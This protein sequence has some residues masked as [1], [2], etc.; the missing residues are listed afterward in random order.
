MSD[1]IL[2]PDPIKINFLTE[3]MKSK[4]TLSAVKGLG[5]SHYL[6]VNEKTPEKSIIQYYEISL[7]VKVDAEFYNNLRGPMYDL[8]F[9][10]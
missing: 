6:L 10:E 7:P 2:V 4:I 3:N 1:D 9:N 5:S 8:Y